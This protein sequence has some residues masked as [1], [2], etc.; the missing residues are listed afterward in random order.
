MK[1]IFVLGWLL[2]NFVRLVLFC[3]A[4]GFHI[5]QYFLN[6]AV[7]H[8]SNFLNLAEAFLLLTLR[9][10]LCWEIHFESIWVYASFKY[11]TWFHVA[12]VVFN[13]ANRRNKKHLLNQ[14]FLKI[15]Q[16]TNASWKRWSIFSYS[17]INLTKVCNLGASNW[18]HI[19][20]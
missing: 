8:Q 1:N 17:C 7:K 15:S 9:K 6:L 11:S 18:H 10:R 4:L 3:G 20:F 5:F 13:T 19:P 14:M 12:N 2:F 16:C